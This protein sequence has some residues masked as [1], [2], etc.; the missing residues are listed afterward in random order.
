M[1]AKKPN[2]GEMHNRSV[3]DARAGL[4]TMVNLRW[5]PERDEEGGQD[6]NVAASNCTSSV[7]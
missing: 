6:E 4:A 3:R 5:S 7:K 2:A 1:K